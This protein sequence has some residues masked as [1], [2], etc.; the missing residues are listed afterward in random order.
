[1]DQ[2]K[3]QTD[4]MKG[5]A[6]QAHR[7]QMLEDI[8]HELSGK[9]IVFPTC[10]E[11]NLRLR[12][13]LQDP[14]LPVARIASI[15]SV[16]PLVVAKLI[17]LANSVLYNPNGLHV[18][19]IPSAITRLGINLVRITALAIASKQM[20]MSK[21][22]VAFRD[23]SNALWNHSI[24]SAAAA[25]VLAR[26]YTHLN[27]DEAMLAGLLHDFGAF[28]MLYRAAQYPEL[29]ERPET[30]KYLIMQWHDSI[31]VSLLNALGLPEEIVQ[32]LLNHDHPRG[33]VPTPLKTLSDVVYVSNILSGAHFEWLYQEIDPG[34]MGAD[35]LRETFREI[36]PEFEAETAEMLAILD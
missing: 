21:E 4:D 24:K 12:K 33:S 28:Y 8:A 14:D 19:N 23:L 11:V 7:F 36:L 25:R 1:M 20:M 3:H 2:E 34:V 9:D 30:V 17:K 32:A 35:A 26:T 18:R 29:C 13:E 31:G 15:V 6:L 22:L 27:P 5:D 10:F 16:E